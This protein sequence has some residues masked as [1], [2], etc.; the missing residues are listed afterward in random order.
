M[1]TLEE[2][3]AELQTVDTTQLNQVE[4]QLQQTIG[5]LQLFIA[6]QV[7]TPPAADPIVTVVTTVTTQSGATQSFTAT[8]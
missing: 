1:K 7:P 5:D 3:L 2:I 8:A 6:N 4:A